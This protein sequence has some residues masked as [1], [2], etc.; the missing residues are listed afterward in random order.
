[1]KLRLKKNQLI[2]KNRMTVKQDNYRYLKE[3]YTLLKKQGYHWVGK[4]SAIK[5]C[6][7]L[8]ESL[9][10][11]RPCYKEKFYGI[12]SHRCMQMSPSVLNCLTY[13][14]HCW[15]A[16]PEDVGIAS[17]VGFSGDWDKAATIIEGIIYEH[18]RILSGYKAQVLA[19]KVDKTKYLEAL[20]PNQ[21]AVS[22]SGE[23]TLYP[24]LNDL[25]RSLKKRGCSVFLVTSGV[26][27]KTLERTIKEDAEPTRLYISLTSPDID[28]YIKI[29]RPIRRDLWLSLM[30]SLDL[31]S[32]F[33]CPTVIRITAIKGLNMSYKDIKGFAKLIE[34]SKCS[35]I[36]V[37]GYMHV[38][39]STRRLSEEN[40]PLFSEVNEFSEHLC[41]ITGYKSRDSVAESRVVLL[42]K[43]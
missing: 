5:K 28:S 42:S 18:R 10:H 35:H 36:E 19:G 40:M 41:D 20:D 34:T 11:N 4:H 7:W 16:M 12:R 9:V 3:M 31:I 15:R 32:E 37:K 13:C 38:G 29:N 23:P 27:P 14:L 21:V 22:L 39:F 25:V 2:S 6:K 24:Y 43:N 1:M 30:K 8:H 17:K 33:R 26:I